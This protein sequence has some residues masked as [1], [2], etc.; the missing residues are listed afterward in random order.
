MKIIIFCDMEGIS[1]VWREQQVTREAP[2]YREA[3]RFMTQ[4]L[5]A[6]IQGC[7]DGGAQQIIVRDVHAGCCN[8]MWE[9]LDPRAAHIIMGDPGRNRFE[10]VDGCDGMILLGYH[11]MAG[12]PQAI[13]AHT[14][15]FSWQHCWM[16]GTKVGEFAL[17]SARA[18]EH[19]V[20]VIMTSGD[21]KLCAEAR[22]VVR[23]VVTVQVKT[24][25]ARESGKL[26]PRTQTLQMTQAGA[27]E[28]VTKCRQ[29]KPFTVKPPVTL[30]LELAHPIPAAFMRAGVTILDNRT[31]EVTGPTV[32][33]AVNTLI[34]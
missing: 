2:G 19:H 14:A 31:Y 22:S 26:F 11:A 33:E 21:D 9:E 29:I 13:L 20:P 16:N 18:G 15:S 8:I 32:E 6:C 4:D 1:G 12:T 10:D 17:D 23:D 25:L 7:L 34:F 28:A 30:R 24:G 27:R 5:N 3:C